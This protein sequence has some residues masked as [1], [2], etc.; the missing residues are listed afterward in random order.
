MFKGLL[1]AGA[2]VALTPSV[3]SAAAPTNLTPTQFFEAMRE[4]VRLEC[5][6]KSDLSSK[7]LATRNRL[8]PNATMEL[9]SSHYIECTGT[10]LMTLEILEDQV[11]T[12]R[13]Q[14]ARVQNCAEQADLNGENW[15]TP[16]VAVGIF[17]CAQR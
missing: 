12:G 2:L 10:G 5:R 11:A 16:S 8:G 14:I 9:R 13:V 3:T 7:A 1:L 4:V 15:H 6:V 17:S